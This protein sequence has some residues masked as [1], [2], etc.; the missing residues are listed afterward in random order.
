MSTAQNYFSGSLSGKSSPIQYTCQKNFVM[1]ATDGNPTGKTDGTQYSPSQWANATTGQAYIDLYNQ[2]TALRSTT[3][4]GNSYDVQTYVIGLGSTVANPT[5]IAGL[6]QMANLGGTGT[7]FLASDQ[8]SLTSALQSISSNIVSKLAA[9]GSVALNSQSVTTSSRVYQGRFSSADWSGQ[10]LS[11]PINPDGSL[12]TAQWDAGQLLNSQNYDTGRA[13]ITQKPSTATGIPFRWPANTANPTAT[14]LDTTQSAA[15]NASPATSAA[16][17]NGPARLNYLRGSQANE[18]SS[19]LGFRPRNVSRL[20]DLVNSAPVWVGAPSSNFAD[21]GYSAFRTTYLNRTPMVYVGANDGMLHAFNASSGAETLAYVPARI[22]G[23]LNQL[24][25]PTYSHQY[26]VDGTPSVADVNYA[27]TWHTVLVA[28]LGAGGKGLYALDITDPSQFSESNAASIALW[29]FTDSTDS[30]MGVALSRPT[31]AKLN[32]GVYAAIFGNGYNNTGTGQA[33]LYI[34]NVQTGALIKKISTLAGTTASPNGLSTPVVIDRDGNRTVDTVYAG[35]LQGNLWKFDLSDTNPANWKIS[36]GT[37][38]APAPL[39]TAK[40]S[41]GNPQ[42]ITSTPD[43]GAHPNGGYLVYFGTGM[44][45]QLSD[46]TNTQSQTVYAIWDNGATVSASSLLQQTVLGTT[47]V[48]PN[49]YRVISTNPINWATNKGWYINLPTSGERVVTDPFLRNGRLIFTSTIPSS[50]QCTYGGSSWLMELDYLTGGAPGVTVFDVN[51]DGT[52]TTA[53]TVQ[54]Q[55]A[56]VNPGGQQISAIASAPAVQSG[57]GS[58]TRPMEM[59]YINQSSGSVTKVRESGS[60]TG[61]HRT[62]WR[63]IR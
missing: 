48:S 10:M 53:D 33:A 63:Q 32:N 36:Y 15:L 62:S 1:L 44:Y 26:Y 28:G 49:S 59:K 58:S 61:S 13:I 22:F 20:G 25:S 8:A 12:G 41:Y 30:D 35:D 4:N 29:E 21:A 51:N 9:A 42:P 5:S 37:A 16:D 45:L 38:T 18:G 11:I 2:I 47:T 56:A 27:S 54:W 23:A 57:L 7:A 46:I 14:E 34:V 6:N 17:S 19:G 60:A 52:V 55:S 50:Q 39:F 3:Y 40:D 24:T 31:I 43:V